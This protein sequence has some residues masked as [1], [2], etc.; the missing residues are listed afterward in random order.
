MVQQ[1]AATVFLMLTS[2]PDWPLVCCHDRRILLRDVV[3]AREGH[4]DPGGIIDLIDLER[5]PIHALDRAPGAAFLRRCR[6]QIDRQG[7][8]N[9]DGFIRPAAL[10][11]LAGEANALLPGAEALTIKRTIYGGKVDASAPEGDPRRREYTHHALQLADD[12]LPADTLVQRLYRC[13]VLT[14]FVRRVQ[15][16]AEL[17]RYADEFQALN[18]VA[19]P[20]GS[21]HGWHY[22]YN[23]CTVTLLLQA[24]EEGGEFTFIPNVRTAEDENRDIVDR[25]LAGDMSHAKTLSRAAGTLTLFRGEYS[26][27]GVTEVKGKLPRITA[28]FTYDEEPDRAASD[29]INIRIYGRR[30]ERILAERSRAASS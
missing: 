18:I 8:C 25:F 6:D 14:D 2:S 30:V 23:E 9:L 17:Y 15:G 11:A 24:A 22:D 3:M 13:D 27:H 7:W 4:D 5:Y 20:P 19:L 16:K 21:W 12:Q 29:E 10:E 28:I 26:L 1:P